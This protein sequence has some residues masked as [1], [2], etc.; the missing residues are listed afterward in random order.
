ML[1]TLRLKNFRCFE[2]HTI[3]LRANNI[4]VGRNNVGKSTIVEALRL[5]STVVE[6]YRFT[7][8]SEV[9]YWVD[10]AFHRRGIYTSLR[11]IEFN[12]KSIFYQYR[13]PPAILTATFISGE[14]IDLHIGEDGKLFAV[15]TDSTGKP[16][17]SKAQALKAN[18]PT[19]GI[20]PQVAPLAP[21]ENILT[22]EYVRRYISTS[23]APLHFRNQIYIFGEH[24]SEFKKLAEMS[25][26]G[27]QIM[28]IET[29]GTLLEKSLSLLVRDGNFVAEVGWM[30][31]GLQ[32]WLQTM[33]FLARSR[34]RCTVILDEPDVYMHADL[35]RKLI[36]LIQGR[37]KQVIVATHSV[38]IM[39]EVAPE[40]ILV[41]ERRKK[42]SYFATSLPAAQKVIDNIG[43]VHNL[44]I[45]RL[46][47]A[48]CCLLV[49]GKDISLLEILQYILFPHS[50]HPIAT[51]PHMSLG[52]WDGWNYAI[53]SSMLLKNAFNQNIISYCILDSD[54]HTPK[55]IK[56]RQIQAKKRGVQLHIWERKEIENYLLHPEA[57]KRTICANLRNETGVPT[58]DVVKK[59]LNQIAENLKD[60]TQ[61]AITNQFYISDKRDGVA[62][63]SR[64]ARNI[65]KQ[66]WKSEE[67]RLSVVCGKKVISELSSWS[68]RIYQVS[69]SAA[70]VA[71][72]TIKQ[73]IPKEVVGVLKA[74]ERR[75]SFGDG[76]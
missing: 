66:M 30:G 18:I 54:Y 8:F 69:L 7:K 16:I 14:T 41:V 27:L 68:Q 33:W 22:I 13:E 57:I 47:S 48:R 73:E 51:L 55:E 58:I 49:E 28:D 46:W 5:I 76:E 60:E 36:R 56:T 23:L 11:K 32:M 21:E 74:I 59:K 71:R 25:W 44:Q 9:P 26:P 67:G 31:H 6:R 52:G 39:S 45:A 38:E 20:L 72:Y 65:I 34:D 29:S 3:P 12:K 75:K 19:I 70:K 42:K 15:I 50:E 61:D 24:F 1:A 40:D 35:Q 17:E 62:K 63:A 10:D 43:G 2:E 4:I 64:E 53:G 37:H